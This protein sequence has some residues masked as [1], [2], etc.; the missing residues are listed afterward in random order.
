MQVLTWGTIAGAVAS[1]LWLAASEREPNDP[2]GVAPIGAAI[3]LPTEPTKAGRRAKPA[4]KPDA[5]GARGAS[6]ADSPSR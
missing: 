5:A 4:N 3:E 6:A 1:A 2:F